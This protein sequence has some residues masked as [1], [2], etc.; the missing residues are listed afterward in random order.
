MDDKKIENVCGVAQS[1]FSYIAAAAAATAAA[2][3]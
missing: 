2:E 3:T 1:T